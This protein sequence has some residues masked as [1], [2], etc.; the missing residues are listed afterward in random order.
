MKDH[1]IDDF[2]LQPQWEEE[3]FGNISVE[4]YE[5]LVVSNF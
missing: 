4:E 5:E 1:F 2:I 3:E